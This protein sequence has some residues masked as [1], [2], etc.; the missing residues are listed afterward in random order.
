MTKRSRLLATT[1]AMGSLFFAVGVNAQEYKP[2]PVAGKDKSAL[3]AGCHGEDGNSMAADFPRLAS[4]YASYIF[5]QV[6][7]F[8]KGKRANNDTMAGIAATVTSMEDLKDIAAY[9]SQQKMAADP[10]DPP[11]ADLV[12][13]GKKVFNEGNPE[14]GLYACVNCH[15][16]NGKGKAPNVAQFPVIGGQHRDY[17][18]KQ[19]NDFREGRRTNDPAGMM[20]DVAKKLSPKEME[21]VANYLSSL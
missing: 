17:I 1:V 21:A 3:C 18:L 6:T 8:Q 16:Q 11:K 12:A 15:G 7:E 20:A 9:F 2:D 4:Q 5:K 10:L 14:T 13:A 19:L